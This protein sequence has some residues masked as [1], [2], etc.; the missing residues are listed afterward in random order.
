MLV[1]GLGLAAAGALLYLL[2]RIGLPLGILP[3]DINVQ[4]E[5]SSFHF[6]FVTCIIVSVVL[7]IV[8]NLLARFLQK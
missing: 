5:R 6:P 7:T 8:L 2:G 1:A 3:G 4:G